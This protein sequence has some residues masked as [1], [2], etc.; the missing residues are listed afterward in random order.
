[1]RPLGGGCKNNKFLKSINVPAFS[2]LNGIEKL[3]TL[4]V[5]VPAELEGPPPNGPFIAHF[6][7]FLAQQYQNPTGSIA[8]IM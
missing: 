7:L 5:I 1:M 8:L 4:F 6:M 2:Y 3:K